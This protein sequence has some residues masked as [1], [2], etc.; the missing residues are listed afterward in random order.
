[1]T[2]GSENDNKAREQARLIDAV[3]TLDVDPNASVSCPRCG[4]ASVRVFD[5]HPR[6][7]GKFDR[8]LK[9][10]TCGPLGILQARL[11]PDGGNYRGQ[12]ADFDD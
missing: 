5:T 12:D 1:M 11:H 4:K 8:Y 2:V 3:R 10:P 6:P 7:D 9:C